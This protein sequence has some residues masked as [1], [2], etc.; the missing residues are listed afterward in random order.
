MEDYRNKVVN[1]MQSNSRILANLLAKPNQNPLLGVYNRGGHGG[2]EP[3]LRAFSQACIPPPKRGAWFLDSKRSW[4]LFP[5]IVLRGCFPSSPP[6]DGPPNLGIARICWE[7]WSNCY[8]LQIYMDFLGRL[9]LVIVEF[10]LTVDYLYYIHVFF[11]QE[12]SSGGI[13]SSIV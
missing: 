1:Y 3:P 5:E 4:T 7:Y 12:S 8:F 13:T 6:Q 10:L 11:F 9:F 2:A